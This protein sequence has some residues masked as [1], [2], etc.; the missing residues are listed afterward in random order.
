M[1]FLLKPEQ[2]VVEA[3]I[4]RKGLGRFPVADYMPVSAAF[5]RPRQSKRGA[6]RKRLR[7]SGRDDP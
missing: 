4:T 7:P 1:D 2:L 3:K 6:G 5:G